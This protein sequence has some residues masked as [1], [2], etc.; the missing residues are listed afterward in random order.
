MG[1]RFRNSEHLL[2]MIGLFV[3]GTSLFFVISRFM[4]P[5]D[6]GLYGH[7]RAG[8]LTD[9]R[10]RPIAFA[11]GAACAQCHDDI[12]ASR[13][14]SKHAAINCQAC[15]GALAGHAEDP[16]AVTPVKPDAGKICVVCHTQLVGRPATMPQVDPADHSGGSPCNQCHN[17]HHP[18]P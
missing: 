7:F 17:P 15:H 18:E 5:R 2:R 13:K 9:E 4:V 8:A 3:V 10:A 12:V 1:S 16:S 6:Y 11:D 14:G